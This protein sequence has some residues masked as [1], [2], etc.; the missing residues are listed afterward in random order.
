MDQE[1]DS[2]QRKQHDLVLKTVLHHFLGDLVEIVEPDF[3]ARVDLTNIEFL[4]QETFS[5]FPGGTRQQADLVARLTSRDGEG[6]IVLVQTE[7]EGRFR[8]KMDKRG[9][10]YYLYLRGKYRVPVLLVAVFLQGGK[11]ALT[12]RQF[13]WHMVEDMGNYG[14]DD[15]QPAHTARRFECGSPNMLGIHALNASLSLLLDVGMEE[16]ESRVTE[17]SELIFDGVNAAAN[18]EPVTPNTAGRYGGIVAFRHK[19]HDSDQCVKKLNQQRI[20]CASRGGNIRYSPH[21][22]TPLALISEA[23]EKANKL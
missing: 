18:L 15:W 17:R 1:Q 13:G 9:F 23:I 14:R 4:E 22:H 20:S 6:R 8:S 11:T 7:V 5:D 3:A 10:Y 19:Q 16:I 12:L 2:D 21:C